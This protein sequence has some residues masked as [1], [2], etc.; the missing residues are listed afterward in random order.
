MAERELQRA[1]EPE[2]KEAYFY[3]GLMRVWKEARERGLT[4]RVVI[5]AKDIPFEQNRQGLAKNFLHPLM[6]DTADSAWNFFIHDIRNHSG[7][8]RHQGGLAIYVIEGKGWTTVDG[9]KYDWEE[10]DLLLLP[11]K[12]GGCEHQHFN[13]EPGKPCKWLAMIYLHFIDRLGSELTQTKVSPD[14]THV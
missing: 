10:G 2:S 7:M 12:K 4:G 3:E 1:R 8:H 11:I 9:V 13:A 14:Y 6:T 5:K